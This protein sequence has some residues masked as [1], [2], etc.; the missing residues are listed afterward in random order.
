MEQRL[1]GERLNPG[2]ENCRKV[3]VSGS[4]GEFNDEEAGS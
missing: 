1:T 2:R 3:C 4:T